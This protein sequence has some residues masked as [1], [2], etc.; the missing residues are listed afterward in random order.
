MNDAK[1]T[2]DAFLALFNA[3]TDVEAVVAL[4]APNAQFWGTTLPE[5]GEGHGVIRTYFASAFSRR[6]GAVVTAT[7][8]DSSFVAL[9]E[10]VAIVLG[11]WQIARS[12][13]LNRLR[14]S[15]VLN[16]QGGRWLIAQFHSSPRPAA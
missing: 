13:N 14:F 12:E 4:F 7:V 5:F 2:L 9:S 15:M 3:G 1:A 8:T 16:R 11:R 10:E 6:A